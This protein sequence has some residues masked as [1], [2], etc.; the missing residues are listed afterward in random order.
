[1]ASVLRSVRVEKDLSDWFDEQF[2]WRGSF[3]SFVEAAL[4]AFKEEWGE[5]KPPHKVL[6]EAMAKM[7]PKY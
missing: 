6:E 2:P 3:P 1:M 4:K 7:A 5:T